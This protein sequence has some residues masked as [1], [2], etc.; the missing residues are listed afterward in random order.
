[1]QSVPQVFKKGGLFICPPPQNISVHLKWETRGS[2]GPGRA[3][4]NEGRLITSLVYAYHCPRPLTYQ[5][6]VYFIVPAGKPYVSMEHM[7][8][9][10]QPLLTHFHLVS[11][12]TMSPGV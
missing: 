9:V 1:M 12:V 4:I 11:P 3:N 8:P 10:L 2:V 6:T 7:A 5:P